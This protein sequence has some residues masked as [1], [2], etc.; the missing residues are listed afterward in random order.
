MGWESMDLL[1]AL[2][3][4][5]IVSRG[6]GYWQ[7]FARRGSGAESRTADRPGDVYANSGTL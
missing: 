1:Y 4:G 3:D 2:S 5:T 7:H 6:A